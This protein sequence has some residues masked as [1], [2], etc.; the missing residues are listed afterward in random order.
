MLERTGKRLMSALD[1]RGISRDSLLLMA[2]IVVA[3]RAAVQ[4]KVRNLSDSGMMGEGDVELA[5]NDRVTVQLRNI[6]KVGG[7]IA[8]HRDKRFGVNFDTIIDPKLARAP[9]GTGMTQAP[10]YARP[11]PSVLPQPI[12]TLNLRKI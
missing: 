9:V 2:E 8:W 11:A 5:V 12:D 6:G 10:R 4:I 7:R 1:T 3:D